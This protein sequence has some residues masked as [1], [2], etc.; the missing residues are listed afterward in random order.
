MS[1][2]QAV[3]VGL[4]FVVVA[5]VYW[6]VP[7]LTGGLVDYAGVTMLLALAVAMSMMVWVLFT[8]ASRN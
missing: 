1:R 7:F 3:L 6:A 2:R 8:G 5:A 4:V